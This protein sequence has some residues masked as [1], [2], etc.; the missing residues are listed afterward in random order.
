MEK[1]L[2]TDQTLVPFYERFG[3]TVEKIDSRNSNDKGDVLTYQLVRNLD[4]DQIKKISPH[5]LKAEKILKTS[6]KWSGNF[7]HYTINNIIFLL[8]TVTI[9]LLVGNHHDFFET[10]QITFPFIRD[11]LLWVILAYLVFYLGFFALRVFVN[12]RLKKK[13]STILIEV[14]SILG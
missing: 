8:T 10:D 11:L 7:S 4:R 5:E 14:K 6:K 2:I 13:L 12:Y 1:K 9:F 3:W